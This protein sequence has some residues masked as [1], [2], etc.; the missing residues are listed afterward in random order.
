MSREVAREIMDMALRQGAEQ[1]ATLA[2]IRESCSDE[3][4]VFY[5]R[6]IGKCMGAVILEV[7][8]PLVERY[9]DLKPPALD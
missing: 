5:R 2:R 6:V 8:N 7:I 4:F 9:P 3:D 1:D